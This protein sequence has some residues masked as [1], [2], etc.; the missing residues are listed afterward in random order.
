MAH[1]KNGCKEKE[2]FVFNLS[3]NNIKL[4][5]IRKRR[6]AAAEAEKRMR[7]G[8]KVSVLVFLLNFLFL[9]LFILQFNSVFVEIILGI[10]SLFI[11]SLL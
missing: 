4:G 1:I 8:L 10:L 7:N 9:I 5:R 3:F 6:K 11:H 2:D